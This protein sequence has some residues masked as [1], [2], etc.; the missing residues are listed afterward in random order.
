M[1]ELAGLSQQISNLVI[2]DLIEVVIELAHRVERLRGVDTDDSVNFLAQ[3]VAS[4][5]RRD[6]HRNHDAT[7]ARAQGSRRSLHGGSRRETVI[8]ENYGAPFYDKRRAAVAVSDFATLHLEPFSGYDGIDPL[9]ANPVG[10]HHVALHD[11][12]TAAGDGAHGQLLLARHTEFSDY[13]NIE[14]QTQLA[15]HFEGDGNATAR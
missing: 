14:G 2:G 15:S 8:D 5:G 10:A 1:R 13:E 4:A 11:D 6:R 7:G 9:L 12:D 3:L